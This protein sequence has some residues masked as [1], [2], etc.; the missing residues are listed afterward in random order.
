[1]PKEGAPLT[2][3]QVAAIRQ[4][5]TEG[6][7]WPADL[8]LQPPSRADATWWSLQPLVVVSPPPSERRGS[9]HPIDAFIGARLAEQG[10]SPN[11]PADRRTLI[12]RATYDLLGLPP[13]PEEV[14]AFVHDPDPLA[15]DRLLD[16][17]LASPHYGER[18]GRHWLDVVRFGESN[19][20]ERNVLIDGLWPFRDWV[21][22]SFNEDKPFDRF[23]REH[24]AGDVFGADEPDVEI[25]TAFLVAGPYDDVGNQDAVQAAQIR[26]DTID[27]IIRATGEA[28]LGL[29]V[30]CARCHDHK[31]DPIRQHD[32]YS[33]YATF[34]GVRHGS[35][36]VATREEQSA[37][38]ARVRPLEERR[39][40]LT[41][42]REELLELVRNRGLDRL[43]VYEQQWTRAPA[44]REG[45]E[46]TFVPVAARFVRLISE[47]Q[48]ISPANTNAF[49]IDEFEVWSVGARANAASGG[50]ADDA[51][52]D[53][54]SAPLSEGPRNVALASAGATASGPSRL[55]E[56]FPGAYGPHLAIDG[57]TGERFLA[58]AGFLQIELPVS[59]RIH[60]VVFSSA[61]GE[62]VP[63]HDK[64][65]FVADY[66]L[67]VSLDGD[68]WTEVA[69][70]HDRQPVNDAHRDHRLRQLA[71]TDAERQQL[72]RLNRELADTN[73]ELAAVPS[74]PTAWV[75]RR[76]SDEA[77]GPFHV[78]L[79]GSP[80]RKGDV[81]GIR[82]LQALSAVTPA[83]ELPA[84]SAEGQR[85]S[86]LADWLV[87][88][89]HP[90]TSRVLANRLWHYHFGTGIVDT[91]SDFGSMGG[92][93]THPELL[94]WLA[95]QL[96]AHEW[97]LKPLHKLIMTSHAYCQS[98]TFRPEAAL[99]DADA[100]WLWRFPPRR[101]AAEEI[102]DTLLCVA[103]QLDDR[104][105]GPGFRLYHFMQD[106]VCTYVPLDEHGPQTYRR[107][108]Y[109]QNARASVVD[110][111]TDFDQPDCAFSI[112]RRAETTSPLQALTLLN[113]DFTLDMAMAMAD[114][115]QREAGTD[116]A[117]QL[118][119]A[120]AL[121]Y[122]RQPTPDE[123]NTCL[124]L[125]RQHGAAA[126]C[127][128]LLNTSEL[129]YV[130]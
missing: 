122:S 42:Q 63:A 54:G 9:P 87:H 95:A 27:E 116:P 1:M 108:V 10:L 107:G 45:T 30:G 111:M 115:L 67:E 104:M 6:A 102:R 118:D 98:S 119:R 59:T 11:P 85:R 64:Y 100:R 17:L 46:E 2:E 90:L 53:G 75:G 83:Y 3:A 68:V 16:R 31:F 77:R 8:V 52:L 80:Q 43:A 51:A 55:I 20:Y 56:D 19:G 4:W 71:A 22:R 18:W 28:F 12:R 60:R 73:R 120:F 121:C 97:R 62:A 130:P 69:N 101:L 39:D 70:S 36:V 113:H 32:Y 76:E 114:R 57:K 58:T 106:N 41:A 33:L 96:H 82:S 91:P 88:P 44:N 124:P 79:G 123:R 78:F 99:L 126:L 103:G 65:A 84:D 72:A 94:D 37:H 129:I 61:R 112:P 24:L 105:G 40:A 128:V 86:A 66:R 34:S 74:L 38:A 35:R 81:V 93:P 127:R 110:L 117:A 5:I 13:T 21:I 23:L 25:G 26:A 48:D 92:R 29:T 125:L 49:G 15:Y 47:G 50:S 14:D 89:D 109:H 7:H